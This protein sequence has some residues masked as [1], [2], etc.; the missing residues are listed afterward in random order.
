MGFGR[1]TLEIATRKKSLLS[2]WTECV[3]LSSFYL[4]RQTSETFAGIHSIIGKMCCFI[5]LRKLV[6]VH[7][8]STEA[9]SNLQRN[10]VLTCREIPKCFLHRIS[11]D[12]NRNLGFGSFGIPRMSTFNYFRYFAFQSVRTLKI[13]PVNLSIIIFTWTKEAGFKGPTYF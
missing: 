5:I 3:S 9:G 1:T 13:E 7:N 10:L 8:K 2:G 4:L 6:L 12:M 11:I